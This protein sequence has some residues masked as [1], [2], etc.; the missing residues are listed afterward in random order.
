MPVREGE[1]ATLRSFPPDLGGNAVRR[2]FDG[3]GRA[4]FGVLRL[5]AAA[6]PRTTG[7]LPAAFT[8][9]PRL[10]EA[11]AVTT[12][13]FQLTGNQIDGRRIGLDQVD[14]VVLRH[15]DDGMT[16]QF[17][18]VERGQRAG[19]VPSGPGHHHG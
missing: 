5:R 14:A 19:T 12:R 11:T 18:V 9:I 2:L 3:D 4:P 8:P 15:E 6:T 10:A 1:T 16:G 13:R 17:V 7:R